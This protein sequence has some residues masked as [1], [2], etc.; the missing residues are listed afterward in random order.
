M[1]GAI[2]SSPYLWSDNLGADIEVSNA[3]EAHLNLL[4]GPLTLYRYKLA[5]RTHNTYHRK[6]QLVRGVYHPFSDPPR[7]NPDRQQ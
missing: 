5:Q 7:A 6:T 2:K 1:G 3:L 4:F